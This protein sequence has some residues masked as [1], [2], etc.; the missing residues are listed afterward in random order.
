MGWWS[1]VLWHSTIHYL[2]YELQLYIVFENCATAPGQPLKELGFFQSLLKGHLDLLFVG[3]TE[4][5]QVAE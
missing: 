3:L 1:S 5:F 4:R 2:Q